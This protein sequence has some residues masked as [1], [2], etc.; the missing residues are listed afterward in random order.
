MSIVC[1]G[2]LS[3]CFSPDKRT[4]DS[5]ACRLFALALM[6]FFYLF[7]LNFLAVS[8][9][10]VGA[11]ICLVC[12]LF[13]WLNSLPHARLDASSF[14][15][16]DCLFVR[17]NIHLSPT[18]NLSLSLFLLPASSLALLPML[19]VTHSVIGHPLPVLHFLA[20]TFS[21]ALFFSH[22]SSAI[23]RSLSHSNCSL[24]LHCLTLP[25]FAPALERSLALPRSL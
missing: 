7:V 21:L 10:Q 9:R 24:S 16:S 13:V 23:A 22:S 11:A 17:S 8:L 5:A 2:F 1:T 25:F 4:N 12:W 15:L 14:R 18:N 20:V 3:L 6:L 19:S